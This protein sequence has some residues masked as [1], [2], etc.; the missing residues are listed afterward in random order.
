MSIELV[1][2]S[3]HHPL[4]PPSPAFNTS[5]H[6]GLFQG[7]GSLH[8]VAKALE[9]QLQH[10]AEASNEYSGLISFRI[11]WFDLFVVQETLKSLLQ[12][13]SWKASI[14][15]CLV[16]FMVQLSNLYMTTRKTIALISLFFSMLSR[17]AMAFLPKS[18]RLFIPWLQ[19]PST[20]ILEPNKIKSVTVSIFPPTYC[21]EVI[22]LDAMI[23]VFWMSG[24][25]P[26]FS[27]SSFTFFKSSLVPKSGVFCVFLLLILLPA[28]LILDWA[29]TSLAFVYCT[30]YRS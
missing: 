20:V 23:L 27:L 16:F 2:P 28:I 9:Q 25:K 4:L 11:D 3:N 19:S 22:G 26:A 14:L 1:M 15:L 24:L 30:L 5:Q 7:V 21:H 8:Q 6:Q 12:H 17:F 10:V 29:S 18:K 13:N